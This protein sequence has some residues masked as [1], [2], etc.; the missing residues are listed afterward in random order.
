[1][2]IIIL[3]GILIQKAIAGQKN[4]KSHV[5]FFWELFSM[6]FRHWFIRNFESQII[7][8]LMNRWIR[9]NSKVKEDEDDIFAK[10]WKTYKKSKGFGKN[11]I[12]DVSNFSQL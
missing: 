7:F 6:I 12:R 9:T 2:G 4:K 3:E 8:Q 5:F 10:L 11:S 1:M